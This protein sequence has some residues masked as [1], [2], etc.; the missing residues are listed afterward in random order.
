MLI[1]DYYIIKDSTP[2]HDATVFHIH[3]NEN[4]TVYQGHFPE[5]PVSPGVCNIQMIKECAENL[6]KKE[7]RISNLQLCRL[8]TLIT[9]QT[10]PDLDVTIQLD[11]TTN[12][13]YKLQ[14]LIKKEEEICMELKAEL[15]IEK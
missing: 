9:P 5:K 11:E 13:I 12:G 10:H 15:T 6:C 2:V 4:S 3:L 7:L 8:T 14:A 1:Q